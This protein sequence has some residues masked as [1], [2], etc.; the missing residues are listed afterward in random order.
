MRTRLTVQTLDLHAGGEPLRLITAGYPT[1][2]LARILERR[3]W[4]REQADHVRRVVCFEPRG[5]RDMYA[6]VL[7]PPS[8]DDADLAV[9]F[10]HNEG[11]STMCGHG[12]LA[13]TTG[14]I[15]EGL[16]PATAPETTIRFEAPAGLVVA[17]AAV[18]LRGGSPTVDD[19]RFTNV[20]S[21]VAARNLD[22]RPDGVTLVGEAAVRGSLRVDVAYGGA[23]YGI[24]DA[25]DLGL[26]VVPEQ[27]EA[28]TRA[29]A[30]IT[31][32]LRRD[33]TPTHPEA[34]DL[35]FI[36]GTIVVDREPASAPDGV[37][38]EAD[39]RNVTIFADA[40][41][42]RSPCGTGTCALL[43]QAVERG[44]LDV[45]GDLANASLTGAIFRGRVEGRATVGE[46]DAIVPS[47]AGRGYVM[48]SST[49]LVD[50]RDPLGDGFL[51]RAAP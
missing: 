31:E 42:D 17:R 24:V 37:A 40:E 51:L 15:E 27:T 11:Y 33:H 3:R 26:R 46:R 8:R 38:I 39:V 16:F 2:P 48:G 9:L 32:V 21:W 36:Y 35:G 7:L 12:I 45:G 34:A 25:E 30:A 6:A 29:G 47:V 14:L 28:L 49:F 19:V 18:T 50:S 10:M 22:V 13:L 44:T 23:F 5:H 4:V 20:A 43:A 41:V 1:V